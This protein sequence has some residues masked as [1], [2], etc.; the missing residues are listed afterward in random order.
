MTAF[1]PAGRW[2][3]RFGAAALLLFPL[4]GILFLALLLARPQP[5]RS[6]AP[7]PVAASL[8]RYLSARTR[9]GRFSGA[10]LVAK[11]DRV[12]FRKGYGF[13]DVAKKIPYTP[14]TRQSVASITK[15]F[16]S[17]AALKLRDDGKLK[18][19]DSVC[20][21]LA[22][23][24]DAWKPITVQQLMRH[25][26]GIPDY[27]A[28]LVLGSPKYL[29][30]MTQEGT[31][32]RLVDEA[33]GRPLDFPPGTKF[34][35]S[36]TGYLVLAQ[37]VETAASKPFNAF[38][39][40]RLLVPA[41]MRRAGLFDGK[42]VPEGLATGYTHPD[43]GWAKLVAGVPLDAGHLVAVPRLPLTPP[44]GDAG[45]Y[46]T[47]DDLLAWSRAMD[48]GALVPRTEVDEVFTPGLDG[49][50]YG[51]FVGEGFKR[52]RTRHNGALPGYVSDFVKFP[53]EGLT[54]VAFSNLDR[55]RLS[56]AVRDVSA[57]VLGEPWDMPVEGTLANLA[58]ED[59]ARLEGR[60][61]MADGRALTVKKD[62]DLLA[63]VLEDRF[64]A[65]LV[66]LSKTRFYFPL[67][68]GTA[69]FTLGEDGTAASVNLR[70]G[71]EDHV[72]RREPAASTP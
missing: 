14:E 56:S 20:L 62:A 4:E 25:T 13:A 45:L 65:G 46:A 37:V 26:S 44:A 7:D 42:S 55:A 60:Y 2:R 71:G 18:L 51:W 61:A 57:I 59:Y 22:G 3:A 12:L 48:G 9:L 68:D 17:M 1:R 70:Y 16:T 52:K 5:S 38:V 63:A 23:C 8:D 21:H 54:L 27:E 39:T 40:E 64:T 30:V 6:D 11:G 58:P 15:M 35:Y 43:L 66:P 53:D 33:K 69:T 72:A 50:G 29:E 19:E 31:S 36:N 34:R 28:P 67:G 49:Y 41:G 32:R 10:V 24:P 47:V